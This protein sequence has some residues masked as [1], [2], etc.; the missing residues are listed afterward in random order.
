MLRFYFMKPA[1]CPLWEFMLWLNNA[2]IADLELFAKCPSIAFLDRC[3]DE[4][5]RGWNKYRTIVE[6]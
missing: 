4:V 2:S 1:E 3:G 6:L 5:R